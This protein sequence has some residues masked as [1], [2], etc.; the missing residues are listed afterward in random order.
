MNR[1]LIGFYLIGLTCTSRVFN[2]ILPYT[3]RKVYLHICILFLFLKWIQN[4]NIPLLVILFTQP[5]LL[6]EFK[7][8]ID[9]SGEIKL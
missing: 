7:K 6:Y 4:Q 2:I 8:V 3:T 1:H 5:I 9:V